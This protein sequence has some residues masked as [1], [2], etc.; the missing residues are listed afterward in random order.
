MQVWESSM[1][2]NKTRVIAYLALRL[3]ASHSNSVCLGSFINKLVLMI[4]I[5]LRFV[6]RISKRTEHTVMT[7]KMLCERISI[8]T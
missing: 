8:Y 7:Q 3:E 6:V 4:E 1:P 2:G 5:L